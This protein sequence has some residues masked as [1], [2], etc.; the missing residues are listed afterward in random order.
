MVVDINKL[1]SHPNKTLLTHVNGVI[2]GTKV[3]TDLKMAEFAAI[4]HG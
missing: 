1:K 3:L 4:F 2:N